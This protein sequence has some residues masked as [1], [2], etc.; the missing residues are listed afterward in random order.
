MTRLLLL[1]QLLRYHVVSGQGELH[2]LMPMTM[3]EVPPLPRAEKLTSPLLSAPMKTIIIWFFKIN[4]FIPIRVLI[5][6][7]ND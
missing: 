3:L 4:I 2:H 7:S 1:H 5:M 6:H